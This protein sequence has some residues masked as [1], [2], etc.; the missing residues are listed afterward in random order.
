L[1]I[2]VDLRSNRT[3]RFDVDLA[4]RSVQCKMDVEVDLT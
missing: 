4:G 2:R 3:V 1:S